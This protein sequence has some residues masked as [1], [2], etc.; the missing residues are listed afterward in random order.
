[1]KGGIATH[2]SFIIDNSHSRSSVSVFDIGQGGSAFDDHCC[3]MTDLKRSVVALGQRLGTFCDSL[4][5]ASRA[6][7]TKEDRKDVKGGHR[8]ISASFDCALDVCSVSIVSTKGCKLVRL[9]S[10][11][12]V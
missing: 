10:L 1:M 5:G 2:R 8:R 12:W 11:R 3:D 7:G 9:S 6:G 4:T